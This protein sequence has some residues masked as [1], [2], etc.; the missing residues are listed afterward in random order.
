MDVGTYLTAC[1]DGRQPERLGQGGLPSFAAPAAE[2]STAA[3]ATSLPLLSTRAS[4]SSKGKCSYKRR[5]QAHTLLALHWCP[6]LHPV[7]AQVYELTPVQSDSSGGCQLV[8]GG[9]NY[10]GATARVCT[11]MTDHAIAFWSPSLQNLRTS[12]LTGVSTVPT[13]TVSTVTCCQSQ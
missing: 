13:F 10:Y 1:C 12:G 7:H 8:L 3:C 5:W 2:C 9:P 4:T 11:K 6:R